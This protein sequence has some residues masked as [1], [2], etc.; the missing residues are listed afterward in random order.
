MLYPPEIFKA[1]SD[2]VCEEYDIDPGCIV[3][4]FYPGGD[5]EN[6]PYPDGCVVLDNP[7]FS[8]LSKIC[9]F[10]L[11]RE[12]P[13][14]LFAPALT[15]LSGRKVVMR[16]NHI[17]C[18]A[19][20]TYENGAVVQTGFVTSFGGDIIIQTAPEL[21]ERILGAMNRIKGANRRE[22]PTYD[23]PDHIMTAAIMNRY[24]HHGIDMKIRR[25][26]CVFTPALDAQREQ[27]KAIFGGGLLLSDQA[28]A[29]RAAA[30]SH[31][32][33]A[34]SADAAIRWPL[35][36]REL[37]IVKKLGGSAT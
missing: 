6:F 8:I 36:P 16:M 14:F 2:W 18:D 31:T 24:A 28:A 35:S 19:K 22:L 34:A 4:P 29:M 5:Y 37:E 3:R 25:T 26:D 20:I 11:E 12:I 23:Y 9:E 21:R 10:Y 33:V 13:F 7:P 27:K 1:I 30:D 32:V 17:L 15:F